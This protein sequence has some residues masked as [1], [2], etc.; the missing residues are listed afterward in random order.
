MCMYCI[1]ICRYAYICVGI[2]I[3][4][5]SIM[6]P[7]Q[8]LQCSWQSTLAGLGIPRFWV[9]SRPFPQSIL[10]CLRELESK[11]PQTPLPGPASDHITISQNM[12]CHKD[13]LYPLA[14]GVCNRQARVV[15][16][17][18]STRGPWFGSMTTLPLPLEEWLW[19]KQIMCEL[20]SETGSWVFAYT[21]S[22]LTAVQSINSS[23]YYSITGNTDRYWW[24]ATISYL[25]VLCL[26]FST[27]SACILHWYLQIH[28]N[29][30]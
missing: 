10:H 18:T 25:V 29:T 2:L 11:L 26:L 21:P 1:G 24:I 30:T 28:W 9:R 14:S 17:S 3:W 5:L 13:A 22:V 7:G 6:L 8:G 12:H 15:P 4:P 20:A 23:T 19:I 27:N 16:C